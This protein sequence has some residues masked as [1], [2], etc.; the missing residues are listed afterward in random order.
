MEKI[1]TWFN[2]L[3]NVWDSTGNKGG[4]TK[5]FSNQINISIYSR[6]GIMTSRR[7]CHPFGWH[8]DFHS[9]SHTRSYMREWSLPGEGAGVRKWAARG[10]GARTPGMELQRSG[11]W[12]WSKI[13]RECCAVCFSLATFP[14]SLLL[15]TSST[16]FG[17]MC[18]LRVLFS[19]QKNHHP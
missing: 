4:S 3:V 1:K 15:S 11:F 19:S 2:Q 7:L 18:I 10:S 8:Y 17:S 13:S 14:G 12:G 9:R 6:I 5:C 16:Q